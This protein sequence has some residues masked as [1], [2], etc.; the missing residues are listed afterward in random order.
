MPASYFS[1]ELGK[2]DDRVRITLGGD[3]AR[4]IE[5]YTVRQSFLTQPAS[6]S[7]RL[8]WGDVV[9]DLIAKYPPG[10]PYQ[11]FIGD[12]L[13]QTGQVDDIEVEGSASGATV[14][15]TGRDALAPLLDACVTADRSFTNSTYADLVRTVL[16]QVL[17][18]PYVLELTN[19]RNRSQQAGAAVRQSKSPLDPLGTPTGAAKARPIQAKVGERWYA[20]VRKQLDRAGLF[21]FAGADGKFI[22]TSPNADQPPTARIVRRR[23]QNRNEVNVLSYRYRNATSPRYDS[24]LVYG[25]GGGRKAGRQKTSATFRDEEMAGYGFP[26]RPLVLRDAHV[27]TAAQAEALARRKIAEARRAGWNLSYRLSGHTVPSL[28]G[29]K[30]V[31]WTVDTTVEVIDDELG[32]RGV[33]W[34]E[35]VEF[36]RA[37]TVTTVN[38]MRPAD[39]LFGGEDE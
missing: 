6:W 5:N 31:V 25:R 12:V 18:R 13:Q 15:L 2:I 30:K 35:S 14:T 20:F 36:S 7:L 38:L 27:A 8:G 37:P 4:I 22:L 32:I 11:L 28:D 26:A 34:V 29:T 23:G 1:D 24:A 9:A 10:T 33:F 39:L 21:L 19:E 3:D 16:A 17:Q